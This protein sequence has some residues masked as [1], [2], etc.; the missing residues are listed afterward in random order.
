MSASFEKYGL[1]DTTEFDLSTIPGGVE[2]EVEMQGFIEKPVSGNPAIVQKCEVTRVMTCPETDKDG[3]PLEV[4]KEDLEEMCVGKTFDVMTFFGPL[5]AVSMR[6]LKGIL[7]AGGFQVPTW[8]PDS[9]YPPRQMI[10]MS[11]KYLAVNRVYMIGKINPGKPKQDGSIPH[12]FNFT[13]V[14]RTDEA[15]VEYSGYIP[16]VVDNEMVVEEWDQEIE[17]QESNPF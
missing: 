3:N 5:N 15:G 16:H 14:S 2:L 7:K 13:A 10:P 17:G 1:A 12:Y 6:V 4:T 8:T 9:K 11:L